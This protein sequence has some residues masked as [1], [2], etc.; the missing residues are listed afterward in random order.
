MYTHPCIKCGTKYQSEDPDPFLCADC[1]KAKEQI[2][3]DVDAKMANRKPN[4][5]KS[6]MQEYEESEK[7]G[8]FMRVKL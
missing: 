5:A 7:V 2:A 4:K 1:E 6:A 8:G 3:K